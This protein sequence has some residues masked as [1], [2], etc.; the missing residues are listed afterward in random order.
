MLVNVAGREDLGAWG[1]GMPWRGGR[2][3]PE[4]LSRKK[5]PRSWEE[6]EAPMG[7]RN[8][9]VRALQPSSVSFELPLRV[10]FRELPLALHALSPAAPH[11]RPS[12]ATRSLTWHPGW[13]GSS[14]LPSCHSGSS[15]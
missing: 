11:S 5:P 7:K 6:T 15:P 9:R 4:C 8:A 14:S 3:V 1:H 2:E 12:S 13:Y 10:L